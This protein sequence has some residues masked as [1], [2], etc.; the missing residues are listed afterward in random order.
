M[1]LIV[2]IALPRTRT[3]RSIAAVTVAAVVVIPSVALMVPAEATI[4]AATA[5]PTTRVSWAKVKIAT[6]PSAKLLPTSALPD[7][8]HK[9]NEGP[10]LKKLK[11]HS[12]ELKSLLGQVSVSPQSCVDFVKAQVPSGVDAVGLKAQA[13]R[14][15]QFGDSKF[16]PYFGE[17]IGRFSSADTA[18]AAIAKAADIADACHSVTATTPYGNAD[19][20][21]T[22]QA[23]HVIGADEAVGY[24]IDGSLGGFIHA[25]GT[26]IVARKGDHVVVIG[27]GGMTTT[28][29][30]EM[31]VIATKALA[32][33]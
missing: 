3:G 30:A 20:S 16:G 13:H 7:G 21:V 14:A 24:T 11:G 8:Y 23:A 26:V 32:R 2:R 5:V 6:I 28:P 18:A 9:L 15:W 27:N 33:V 22:S 31:E 12:G 17:G 29:Y 25:S 10:L 1:G 4:G 19:V